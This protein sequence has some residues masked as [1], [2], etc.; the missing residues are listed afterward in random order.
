MTKAQRLRLTPRQRELLDWFDRN[1]PSLREAYE[2]VIRLLSV[3]NFPARV[4]LIG[5]LVRE[6]ANR[7]PDVIEGGTS[8]RVQYKNMLDD[9]APLWQKHFHPKPDYSDTSGPSVHVSGALSSQLFKKIDKLVSVHRES[10]SRP[11]P[12]ERLFRSEVLGEVETPDLLRPMERQFRKICGWF[13]AKTHLQNTVGG[14]VP[15]SELVH[16]FELFE[17]TLF[18][19][20]G[21]FFKGIGELDEILQDTNN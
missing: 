19:L 7:L 4:P 6:I 11:R 17:R 14:P 16:K 2:A 13:M 1:A 21:Q 18:A 8:D 12:E 10:R 20:K 3:P 9:I 5:H 15:E